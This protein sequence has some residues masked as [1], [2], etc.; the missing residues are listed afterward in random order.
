MA[1]LGETTEPKQLVQGE[2]SAIRTSAQTLT[3]YGATFIEIGNG[4]RRLDAGGWQGEAGDAF[5]QRFATE[6]L[7][8]I[9]AGDAFQDAARTMQDYCST[10]EWGQAQAGEAIHEYEAGQRATERARTEYERTPTPPGTPF[11]DPGEPQRQAA[12]DRLRR[13]RDQVDDA[14]HRAASAMKAAQQDAPEKPTFLDEIGAALSGAVETVGDVPGNLV[15]YAVDG[16]GNAVDA[17]GTTAA[18]VVGGAGAVAEGAL[19]LVGFDDAAATVQQSADARSHSLLDGTNRAAE[20]VREAADDA[21]GALGAEDPPGY[22]DYLP[23]TSP[24]PVIVKSEKYP[25]SA[26]HIEEAQAGFISRG[27]DP[28]EETDPKP[29]DVTIDKE[30]VDI[31]RREALRGIPTRGSENLDRDEYPPAMFAEGGEGSSV[32]FIPASDNRGSG[33]SMNAQIRAQELGRGEQVRILVE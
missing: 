4:F 33:A 26:Q 24:Q 13:A 7:R 29:S 6:P 31:N 25:D 2:P 19:D 20:G 15:H 10:L 17:A 11:D 28:I 14:G 22:G 27:R 32:K 8:W 9:K 23:D 30:N 1:E 21:A 16:F 5:R 12:R 3:E 18:G